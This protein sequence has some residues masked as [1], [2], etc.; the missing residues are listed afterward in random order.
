MPASPTHNAE[1]AATNTRDGFGLIFTTD[2]PIQENRTDAYYHISH[3][4][5]KPRA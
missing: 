5:R 4:Q 3:A 2:S 1:A